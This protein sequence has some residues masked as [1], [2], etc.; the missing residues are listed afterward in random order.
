MNLDERDLLVD[1]DLALTGLVSGSVDS[2]L[3]LADLVSDLVVHS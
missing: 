1:P 3:A 2:D